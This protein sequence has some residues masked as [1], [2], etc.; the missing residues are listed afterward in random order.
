[1]N[2]QPE[3]I[4]LLITVLGFLI[5]LIFNILALFRMWSKSK[6]EHE[7]LRV[8]VES[9]L[10][11]ITA[12]TDRLDKDFKRHELFNERQFEKYHQETRSDFK[13]LDGKLDSIQKFLLT[14]R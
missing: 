7:K 5:T 2:L 3:T 11:E 4:R 13:R 9:K 14:N 12:N 8:H 6:I 10:L 1:M